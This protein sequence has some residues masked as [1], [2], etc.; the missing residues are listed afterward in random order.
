MLIAA[1]EPNRISKYIKK[2]AVVI[3]VYLC[4]FID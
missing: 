2:E 4:Q 3:K 1:Y